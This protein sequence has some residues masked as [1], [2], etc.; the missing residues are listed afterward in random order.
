MELGVVAKLQERW[1]DAFEYLSAASKSDP[2]LLYA[3]ILRAE[4]LRRLG[5]SIEAIDIL[6]PVS[7]NRSGVADLHVE[8]AH[9]ARRAGRHDL[10][11]VNYRK[12]LDLRPDSEALLRDCLGEMKALGLID[13][14]AG[15]LRAAIDR[16]PKNPKLL[17]E[18]ADILRDKGEADAAL[19]L[20]TRASELSPG[21]LAPRLSAVWIFLGI[22][23]YDEAMRAAKAIAADAPASPAAISIVAQAARTM[24]DWA[25]ASDAYEKLVPLRPDQYEFRLDHAISLIH[26]DRADAARSLLHDVPEGQR[27]RSRRLTVL[28]SLSV[29]EMSPDEA[30]T[31]LEEARRADPSDLKP[32]L[33]AAEILRNRSRWE[34]MAAALRDAWE[35]APDNATV[36][37]R[38]AEMLLQLRRR[39]D[40][41]AI[42]KEFIDRH[43]GSPQVILRLS[44]IYASAGDTKA[45][46]ALLDTAGPSVRQNQDTIRQRAALQAAEGRFDEAVSTLSP[47]DT[48]PASNP[49]R[50]TAA[51]YAL[52]GGHLD[53]AERLLAPGAPVSPIG[54]TQF[55]MLRAS[56]L[57]HRGRMAEARAEVENVLALDPDLSEAHRI[58]A[59]YAI[60]NLDVPA[61]ERHLSE[62]LRITTPTQLANGWTLSPGREL[63]GQIVNELRI[64]PEIVTATL[65][66]RDLSTAES[67]RSLASLVL[68][69]PHN[70]APALEL[71]ERL[72]TGNGLG[73]LL[74][75]RHENALPRRV[76]QFWPS[77]SI[78]ADVAQWMEFVALD[79]SIRSYGDIDALRS[80][81]DQGEPAPRPPD[82]VSVHPSSI[83]ASRLH[84]LVRAPSPWRYLRRRGRSSTR[85]CH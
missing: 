41:I 31:L 52:D 79:P 10:A 5:R 76:T 49:S 44:Q 29:K 43:P 64:E 24:G 6:E 74:S 2:S 14:A 60:R 75:S 34:E 69:H 59:S 19:D 33:D 46:Q 70:I 51:R 28:A 32:I 9:N 61:I 40:A 54:A 77:E 13:E 35:L 18:L 63:A 3:D 67:S 50:L 83:A 71:V 84:A 80:R 16:A 42:L 7:R 57:A 68:R 81:V 22:G 26:L 53:E 82:R 12:A 58:A 47:P 23:R 66:T 73:A 21:D 39:R 4:I 55:H 27:D 30:L 45:A 48:N 25:T 72:T 17:I 85:R 20:L 56:L 1:T 78:P 36:A 65:A 8:L 15:L 11:L 38:V 62:V 37:L